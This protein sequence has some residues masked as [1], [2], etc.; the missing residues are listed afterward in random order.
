MLCFLLRFAVAQEL[1]EAQ[2]SF[3]T[4]KYDECLRLCTKPEREASR[5][6]EW[7]LLHAQTLLATGR[8]P[9]AEGVVSNAGNEP[10]SDQNK[11]WWVQ[12]EMMA[13]LTDALRYQEDAAQRQALDQLIHF[14][15]G[16]QTDARTGVWLDTVTAEGQ[17]KSTGLAH[18]WK[19][20]YHDVRALAKFIEFFLPQPC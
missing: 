19:T 1:E 2:K 4:G 6:E 12:A 15:N 10:A 8:Y 18:A 17:P 7:P 9:P 16:Y 14:V 11:I 13:A 5:N 20:N 3:L